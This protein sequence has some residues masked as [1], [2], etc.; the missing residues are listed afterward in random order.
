VKLGIATTV[1]DGDARPA[2]RELALAVESGRVSAPLREDS[3]AVL[4]LWW[5]LVEGRWSLVERFE[6]GGRRYYVAQENPPDRVALASLDMLERRLVTL[7][8]TGQSEKAAAHALGVGASTV[9]AL[10][11]ATLAKLGLR[12]RTDLV[13]F[14]HAVGTQR[15]ELV[16]YAVSQ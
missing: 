5:G 13:R 7:I 3:R 8:G 10:L 1:T 6:A 16:L 4:A 12:S 11:K 2:L 14:L 15:A 9:S